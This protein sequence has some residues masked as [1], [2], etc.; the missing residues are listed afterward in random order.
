MA[1]KEPHNYFQTHILHATKE[2]C[3]KHFQTCLQPYIDQGTHKLIKVNHRPF[4][5]NPKSLIHE[6][7]WVLKP[8]KDNEE[9]KS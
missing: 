9:V 7:Q 2:D 6:Y 5:N 1:G 3:E 4:N 8:L